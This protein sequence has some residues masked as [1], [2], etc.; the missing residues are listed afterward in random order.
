[1]FN[2]LSL[3]RCVLASVFVFASFGACLLASATDELDEI[4]TP[5]REF[6]AAWIATVANIDWPT[7][8]GLSSAQQQDE[9][10]SLLDLAKQLNLNAVVLQIRPSCDALYPS[11][12]EP[13]SE[14]LT[15]S[16]GKA[17]VP[18]YDPLEFAV[19]EAHARGLELHAWFNPYRALHPSAKGP[20]S[21]N[22]I[23]KREPQ[24]VKKYGKYLWLDPGEP[25][26]VD[27]SIAVVMDVVR[28]YDVDGVHL[29]DY[30]YPYPVNDEAG[31]PVSFPD[32]ASWEKA[33][34]AGNTLS[35]DD[36][37]RQNVDNFVERLYGE[38]KAE[39]RWV[40]FGISPF[41]I[42]RPGNP[43]QIKGFDQYAAIYADARKWFAEGWLDYFA[44]QLY[45][46]IGK[47][48][49]SYPA[50]LNWWHEQNEQ[51]RHLWPGNYT[52]RLLAGGSSDWTA[53]EIVAQVWT[54]RAQAGADGNIHFSIK[55]LAG[56][57]KGVA[58]KLAEGPYREPALV[59]ASPW[60]AD[61]KQETV[62]KPVLKISQAGDDSIVSFKSPTQPWLWVVRARYGEK[63]K[64]QLVAGRTSD[65]NLAKT[66]GISAD[67]G[68]PD[69]VVVSSIDRIG[70]ES[71]IATASFSSP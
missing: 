13:W 64:I 55:A 34:A 58:N 45:W 23:S 18:K 21:D 51:G 26:A 5:V 2:Q 60:L 38:I 28:R 32:D 57:S 53:D 17:P 67:Q 44:P 70:Q 19:K 50:L 1:M 12:L 22:H 46:K 68:K 14:F 7:K 69:L 65:C 10:L 11:K 29:D 4:P 43:P 9:L 54:T 42:W 6:R 71:P 3:R 25:K 31:K 48:A 35:R 66:F 36:W 20:V 41:G 27:H 62:Q 33:R 30:F 24:L 37:R 8:S 15:G 47:T 40:K 39:K 16:M 63:W 49:Q 52:S 61:P 59:P 56:N